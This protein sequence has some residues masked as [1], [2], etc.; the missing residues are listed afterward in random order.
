VGAVVPAE[1]KLYVMDSQLNG[2]VAT[3]NV[4]RQSVGDGGQGIAY[5]APRDTVYVTNFAD[6]SITAISNPC[7]P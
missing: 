3:R 6:N 1:D 5:S 7:H 2:T 4:G